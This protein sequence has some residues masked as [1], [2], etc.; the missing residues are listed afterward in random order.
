MAKMLVKSKKRR[1]SLGQFYDSDFNVRLKS[2]YMTAIKRV[3]NKRI[4]I[5][6]S[7]S[8]FIRVAVI[9]LLREEGALSKESPILRSFSK[10]TKNKQ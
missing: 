8:H 3:V 4:D 2:E 5:Y 10:N 7:P 6:D 9:R 1:G